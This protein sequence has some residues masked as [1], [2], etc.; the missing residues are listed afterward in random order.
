MSYVYGVTVRHN[1]Y[2]VDG[3]NIDYDEV[4]EQLLRREQIQTFRIEMETLRFVDYYTS[5]AFT[6]YSYYMSSIQV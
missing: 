2:Q 6:S 5:R 4:V 3:K 1:A